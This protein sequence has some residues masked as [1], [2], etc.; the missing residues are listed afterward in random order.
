MAESPL[1][2]RRAQRTPVRWLTLLGCLQAASPFV[3]SA[4]AFVTK[5]T[6]GKPPRAVDWDGRARR[7]PQLQGGFQGGGFVDYWPGHTQPS[8][9][10]AHNV[11]TQLGQTV[12]LNC[13]V[14]NLGDKTVTWIRRRDLHVLTVGLDTYIGDPRFQ[15]IHLDRSNDWALQIRYAQLSDQGLYECQVSTDPKMSLFV[16]LRILEARAEV[17]NGV[18]QLFLKTGSTINLTCVI[19]Q[20]PEP[21]VFVFWFHNNRMINYDDT[22]KSETMVRRAGRNAAISRLIIQDAVPADSGNYTCGPSNA[23]SVTVAVFVLNGEKPAAIQRGTTASL[24]GA[25]ALSSACCCIGLLALVAL[26]QL[27]R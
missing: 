8:F 24:S 21:P 2:K 9:G 18:G 12:Y 4:E 27:K 3:G 16:H 14:S 7:T 26:S 6:W 22:A 17:E 10:P 15:P 20:S 25:A 19:T 11:T 1:V 23:D 13:I 5:G